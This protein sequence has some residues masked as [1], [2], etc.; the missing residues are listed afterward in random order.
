[1][2]ADVVGFVDG[3]LMFRSALQPGG[4]Q[5]VLRYFVDSLAV[6]VPTPGGMSILEVL[7]REPAPSIEIDGLAQAQGIQLEAGTTFRRF[8]G[9]SITL[10]EVSLRLV[11]ESPPP[12]VEWI[13][14]VLA[15]VLAAGGLAALRGGRREGAPADAPAADGGRQTILLDLARLDEEYDGVKAPSAART[16]EY[17]RRRAEL[18]ER[19]RR[20]G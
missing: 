20:L 5:L 7:V 19:L 2:S 8:S 10:P 16:K 9:D 6:T 15:L 12:P 3:S 14:V 18:M 4:R 11:E 13:A 17:Q 1:M